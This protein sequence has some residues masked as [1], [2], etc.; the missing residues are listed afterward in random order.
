M[1]FEVHYQ[2]SE[3]T[4]YSMGQNTCKLKLDKGLVFRM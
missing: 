4:S 1:C 2:E 3:K